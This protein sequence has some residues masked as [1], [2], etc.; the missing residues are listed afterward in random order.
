MVVLITCIQATYHCL[1]KQKKKCSK[2]I[3]AINS[4]NSVKKIKGPSRPKQN[5]KIR[6]KILEAINYVDLIILFSDKTPIRLIKKIK[7][8][9]L[10]KGSDYKEKQII[11]AQEVKSYGGKVLRAKIFQDFSSSLVID[12]ILHSSF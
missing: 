10:V 11:G 2:L 5:E 3:V 4:D 1:N 12:E 9:L 7:P 8:N 6:I